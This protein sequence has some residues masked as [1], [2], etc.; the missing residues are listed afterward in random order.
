M[1]TT[2]LVVKIT[3]LIRTTCK[4][5]PEVRL[6]C[7]LGL[8]WNWFQISF[9]SGFH[10][11]WRVHSEQ[12][13]NGSLCQMRWENKKWKFVFDPVSNLRR[14]VLWFSRLPEKKKNQRKKSNHHVKNVSAMNSDSRSSDFGM[15][16]FR[17]LEILITSGIEMENPQA[18]RNKKNLW[19]IISCFFRIFEKSPESGYSRKKLEKYRGGYTVQALFIIVIFSNS[20]TVLYR[21]ALCVPYQGTILVPYNCKPG[22]MENAGKIQRWLYG[23]GS[24]YHC[25]L[26]FSNSNTVS[27]RGPLFVPYLKPSCTL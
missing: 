11:I 19:K 3:Y 6:P 12:F 26:F 15:V 8:S 24:F 7:L 2:K 23:T 14:I 21:R 20:N 17:D 4:H 22:I 10:F 13:M 27:Y 18:I 1:I 25:Y 16:F 5:I 9:F